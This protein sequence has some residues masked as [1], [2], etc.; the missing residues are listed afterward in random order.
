MAIPDLARQASAVNA[1]LT[2]ESAAIKEKMQNVNAAAPVIQTPTDLWKPASVAAPVDRINPRARYGTR[3]GEQ[4]IDTRAMTK[5]LGFF[6]KA[7]ILFLKQEHMNWKKAK[8]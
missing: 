4:R 6:I 2:G 7:P 1:P 8:K 5:P 3:P